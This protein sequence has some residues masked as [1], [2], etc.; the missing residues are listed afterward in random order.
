[1]EVSDVRRQL[2]G[3][4]E[5]ARL[6]AA[7]RRTRVDAATRA[8][9]TFLTG[10]AVP[11][12]HVFVQALVGEGH[13]FRVQTPGQAVRLVPDRPTEEYVE[14]AL[15]SERDVPAVVV[16]TIRGRGRRM[17]STERPVGENVEI[18][19]LTEQDVVTVVLEELVPF[20]ER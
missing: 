9:D 2:R 17:L 14:L 3:A 16:R 11:I 1:M 15:D 7:E 18:A 6:R 20:L 4:I 13:R 12:F 5:E 10:V 8:Y 19:D